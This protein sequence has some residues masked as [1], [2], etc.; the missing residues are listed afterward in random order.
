[1]KKIAKENLEKAFLEESKAYTEYM[2]F[3]ELAEKKGFK[4]LAKLFRAVGYSE[5]IHARNRFMALQEDNFGVVEGV[6]EGIKTETYELTELYLILKTVAEY[7][8]EEKA[9]L[10]FDWAWEAEKN[11]QKIFVDAKKMA[12]KMKM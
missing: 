9:A 12:E 11:H 3:G 8:G 5:L 7:L 2:I 4:S 1:M 6:K 10:S